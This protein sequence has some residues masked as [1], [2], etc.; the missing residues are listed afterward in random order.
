[1]ATDVV[2]CESNKEEIE[3]LVKRCHKDREWQ[4]N[5]WRRMKEL[6]NKADALKEQI[7]RCEK[8][9]IRY[10]KNIDDAEGDDIMM[11]LDDDEEV[12]D[13]Q[14]RK[15]KSGSSRRRRGNYKNGNNDN[16]NNKGG[17][18]RKKN[19]RRVF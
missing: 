14:V 11:Q 6:I 3:D 4:K 7:Q 13:W 18:R 1:M 15:P 5:D 10:E 19:K 12:E 9:I 2:L 16:N 8:S 17:R